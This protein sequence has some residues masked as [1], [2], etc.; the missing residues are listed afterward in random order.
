MLQVETDALVIFI[1]K[2]PFPPD[3]DMKRIAAIL[4]GIT[5]AFFNHFDN[6]FIT[7]VLC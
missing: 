7:L 5:K 3:D 4:D 6:V 2:G 1:D